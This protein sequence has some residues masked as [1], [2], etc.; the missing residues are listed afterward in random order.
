VAAACIERPRPRSLA[1]AG[2]RGQGWLMPSGHRGH[3]R[4]KP[5]SGCGL[6]RLAPMVTGLPGLRQRG[7]AD[8]GRPWCRCCVHPYG[9]PRCLAQVPNLLPDGPERRQHV[10][11]EFMGGC[12]GNV[13]ERVIETPGRLVTTLGHERVEDVDD[14]QDA[15]EQ[16]DRCPATS[17]RVSRL[18]T[19]VPTWLSPGTGMRSCRSGS[20]RHG[21]RRG[22]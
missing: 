4:L 21:S 22:S 11:V 6:G 5:S 1:L 12:P 17:I 3:G 13:H 18:L 2:H 19:S 15:C 7:S 14:R 9:A 20:R 8:A 10:R 16:R